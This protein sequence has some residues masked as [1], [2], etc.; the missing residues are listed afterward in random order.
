MQKLWEKNSF[1][2]VRYGI[3]LWSLQKRKGCMI[4]QAFS[5][6]DTHVLGKESSGQ[7]L[8]MEEYLFRQEAFLLQTGTSW[9]NSIWGLGGSSVEVLA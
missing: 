5:K 9:K 7:G 4:T 8:S 6:D 1:K 3:N 2:G